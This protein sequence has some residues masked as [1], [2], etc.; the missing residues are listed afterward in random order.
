MA[1]DG[2]RRG[3]LRVVTREALPPFDL[4]AELE[5]SRFASIDVIDAAY[6][7]LVK[8]HHPDKARA[9]EG[10]GAVRVGDADRI[11]RLNLAHDWL[12]DPAR[13]DRYDKATTAEAPRSISNATEPPEVEVRG[14]SG[15]GSSKAFGPNTREVRQ[16]LAELRS[17]DVAR[18]TQ[19]RDAK[20]AIDPMA[21]AV[22]QHLA[23]TAGQARRESEWLL[24][25]EAASVIA[26]G[27]LHDPA[28]ANVVAGIV[29]DVAGAIAIQDLIPKSDFDVLLSPWTGTDSAAAGA[30]TAAAGAAG[31]AGAASG[32]AGD[33]SGSNGRSG[34]AG[35]SDD[36]SGVGAAPRGSS[37][38]VAGGA[39]RGGR[40]IG[41][42]T[43]ILAIVGLIV[44]FG[45]AF[46]LAQPKAPIS[47]ALGTAD[48]TAAGP[49]LTGGPLPTLGVPTGLP[50]PGDTSASFGPAASAS[51]SQ[52]A[53]PTTAPIPAPTLAP[54]QTPHPTPAPTPKVT[55][56]PTPTSAPTPVPTPAPTPTPTPVPTQPMCTVPTLVG[57]NTNTA[58]STWTAA[59]FTSTITFVDALTKPPWKI[60]WQSTAAGVSEL[61]TSGISVSINPPP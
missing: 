47:A 24:A 42:S 45:T 20:A 59:G 38:V 44:V 3:T 23:L 14:G 7:A 27:K 26:K 60:G 5:V 54:G 17:I 46:M 48:P 25:R 18:A 21:F 15:S 61:C 22:A 30:A 52:N 57:L 50:S 40:R 56:K 11:K 13:R 19:V 31:A 8:R 28:L 9:S 1:V 10:G 53:G 49:S 2:G 12:T 33:G 35:R 43:G 37:R 34:S 55:P 32:A 6:R 39:I 51:P 16:L 41:S 58:V 36:G 4:Y 29:A